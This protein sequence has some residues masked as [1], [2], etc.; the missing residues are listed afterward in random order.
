[1]PPPP[2]QQQQGRGGKEVVV[3]G[4][5]AGNRGRHR[6]FAFEGGASVAS[7][8]TSGTQRGVTAGATVGAGSSAAAAAAAAAVAVAGT[9]PISID[10]QQLTLFDGLERGMS[11]PNTEVV[12]FSPPLAGSRALA[13]QLRADRCGLVCHRTVG[14]LSY[15]PLLLQAAVCTQEMLP[16]A[17]LTCTVPCCHSKR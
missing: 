11:A 12:P 9:H 4:A 17:K 8:A 5:A 1:V 6:Q 13:G 15:A 14:A 2:Q 16:D 10:L 7:G 3:P